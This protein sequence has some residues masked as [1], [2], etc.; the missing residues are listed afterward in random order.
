[1]SLDIC[2]PKNTLS[3][4]FFT[5]FWFILIAGAFQFV[6]TTRT[7]IGINCVFAVLNLILCVACTASNFL[8]SHKLEI[9]DYHLRTL[10]FI[11]HI[12]ISYLMIWPGI[13]LF[14]LYFHYSG[15]VTLKIQ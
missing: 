4:Q 2:A 3:S 11:A 7:S 8:Q 13:I 9:D 5:G 15:R 12:G 10:Y 14:I 6:I 1:M